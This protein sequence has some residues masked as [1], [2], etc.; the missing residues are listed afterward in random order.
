MPFGLS[1]TFLYYIRHLD[2]RRSRDKK[3]IEESLGTGKPFNLDVDPDKIYYHIRVAQ[4]DRGL[5]LFTSDEHS[6]YIYA[7]M[8]VV[9]NLFDLKT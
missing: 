5:A 8:G 1:Y 7:N 4:E 6:P 3:Q 9:S 2:R